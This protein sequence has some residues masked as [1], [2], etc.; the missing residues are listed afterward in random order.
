MANYTEPLSRE[1][2]RRAVERLESAAEE[3]GFSVEQWG[4]VLLML[5]PEAYRDRPPKVPTKAPPGSKE[6]R[7]ELRQRVRK[8]VA[9]HHPGDN[10]A[11]AVAEGD[12][13]VRVGQRG[14]YGASR[15]P[16][17]AGR[18]LEGSADPD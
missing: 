1:T 5:F 11:V 17:L 2:A 10:L 18:R 13:P 16:T 3:L 12:R 8:G 9:L 6:K 7:R 14:H 15:T 4:R